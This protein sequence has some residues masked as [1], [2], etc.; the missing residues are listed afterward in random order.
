MKP[1]H[2]PEVLVR[3]S[4]RSQQHDRH[5]HSNDEYEN[6]RSGR[7]KSNR[8][9]VSRERLKGIMGRE[10]APVQWA[11]EGYVPE[12][13]SVLAGRQNLAKHGLLLIWVL[14]L[15]L[16]DM[17]LQHSMPAGRCLYFDLENGQRRIKSRVAALVPAREQWPTLDRIEFA[18]EC[19]PVNDGLIPELENWFRSATNPRLIVIDVLQRIKPAGK[20][21]QNSYENDYSFGRVAAMGDHQRGSGPW[22]ASH[23]QGRRR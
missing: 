11:V 6:R 18:G 3:S 7:S 20:P 13:F 23:A 1:A 21:G 5:D 10:F 19:P 15:E 14:P 17:P 16:A 12:G 2:M 9:P 8:K 4:N 22:I